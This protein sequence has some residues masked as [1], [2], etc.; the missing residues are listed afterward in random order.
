MLLRRQLHYLYLTDDVLGVI[1]DVQHRSINFSTLKA[2]A[3]VWE[4]EGV[5]TDMGVAALLCPTFQQ[6][7]N[8][9]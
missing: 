9:L 3:L 8:S 2:T 1:L 6:R 4:G 7:G 5:R